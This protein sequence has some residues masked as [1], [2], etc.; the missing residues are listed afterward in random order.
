MFKH[1]RDRHHAGVTLAS[2]LLEYAGVFN[3]LV[4]ALPRGGVPVAYEV[5]KALDLPLDVLLV[6]KLGLP[7]HEELAMGAIST[8]GTQ[9]INDE[10]LARYNV[11]HTALEEVLSFEQLEL[12]RRNSLYRQDQ[13]PPKVKEKTIIVIDDGLATGATMMAAI[14]ALREMEAATII[15]ACP[16]GAADTFIKLN[17]LADKVVCLH[18]PEPFV[19]VGQWYDD[20]SQTSDQQVLDL[21]GKSKKP[22]SP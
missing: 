14:K 9:V 4:L 17:A 1:F 13:P 6:R 22:R 21:L 12:T 18:M 20:F 16:V 3:I 2:K 10:I 19:G 5:A 15:V 8:G 7:S 11:S